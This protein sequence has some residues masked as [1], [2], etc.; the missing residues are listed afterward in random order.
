MAMRAEPNQ[1][2]HEGKSVLLIS[3]HF[4]PSAAVGGLRLANFARCLP[5]LGWKPYVLTINDSS[6]E[7]M[8]VERL[9]GLG[10]VTV[11]KARQL[12]TAFDLFAAISRW[13]SRMLRRARGVTV[14]GI[15]AAPQEF[16]QRTE[17]FPR[18]L[19]RY[20]L[21]FLVLPDFERGW[22]LPA[23]WQTAQVFRRHQVDWI[24][25]SCPPYSAHVVGLVAKKFTGKKWVADFR[26]PW[27]TA[28]SKQ[29]YP[30][31]TL[32]LVVDSWLE[33]L[34]IKNSD[35]LVFNVERLRNA[36]RDK[37]SDQPVQKF[38]FIP[39]GIPTPDALNK[40][41]VSKY[42]RFTLTYT[43]S[44]YAGRTPEPVFQAVARLIKSGRVAEETLRIKLVGHCRAVGEQSMASLLEKYGLGSIVEI[45]DPVPQTEAWDILR[46]S[47]IA[48]LLAPGL[49]F[50]IPA[51]L[52]DYLGVGTRILAIAEDG[53]TADLVTDSDCGRAFAPSDIDGLSAFIHAEMTTQAVSTEQ[54]SAFLK[55]F[56][57]RKLTE[58]LAGHLCQNDRERALRA[59]VSAP[60]GHD[61]ERAHQ[62][63]KDGIQEDE[64]CVE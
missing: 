11:F 49:P 32:S 45:Q 16:T 37:Y 15:P 39:N 18:R 54:R 5:L 28:E 17:T 23:L 52:Y 58:Q 44:L 50:Q 25:T 29:L 3:Y 13:A 56:E 19:H 63:T 46:R 47:H 10:G 64:K 8:D 40:E 7:A 21:S 6:V 34:V 12:P 36:Y 43:G 1:K 61:R 30:T 57:V 4:P 33:L 14:A 35:L 2:E 62:H 26:D 22:I 27:M 53:A 20:V 42:D 31:S 48:L 55:R 41:S 51:K 59:A 60:R 38:V 9:R 24:L